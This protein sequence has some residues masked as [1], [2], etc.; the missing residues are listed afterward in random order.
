MHPALR[1]LARPFLLLGGT[2]VACSAPGDAPT[3]P[4]LT[5]ELMATPSGPVPGP[6]ATVFGPAGSMAVFPYLADDLSSNGRDPVNLVFTGAADPRSLRA[7][8]L[9][10]DGNRAGPLAAF[11]CTWNDA[12]G[13]LQTAWSGPAGWVGSA[14]QLECGDYGPV[15]F[16]LRFFEVGGVTLGG[17]HFEFLI[18]GTSDHQVVSWELA[19][20][21]VTYDLAR[22]GLLGA[23]PASTGPINAAPWFRTIPAILYALASQAD[24]QFAALL[25]MLGLVDLP[26]GDKGIPTDGAATVLHLAAVQPLVSGTASQDFEVP[27][28]Q[29]IPKPFCVAGAPSP[30]LYVT[31]AVRLMLA[32]TQHA[33]GRFEQVMTARGRLSLL[34]WNPVA[35]Q[36]AGE[37]Y[38]AEVSETQHVRIDGQGASI[39]G[40]QHQ[41]EI[42]MGAAG[43]GQL[44]VRIRVGANGPPHYDREVRCGQP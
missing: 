24:P 6:L 43:H 20:Q 27:F 35:N 11:T 14:I 21:L 18:P 9:G 44:Q 26:G 30:Y 41:L 8:L 39:Q 28:G 2:L 15:R 10:L 31:G 40:T 42:P 37:A 25:G 22:T 13:G 19:E 29:L 17:A 36:P 32:S 12:V 16:H 23:A 34:P 4:L 33:D 5:P 7:A 3:A 38:Q 1:T